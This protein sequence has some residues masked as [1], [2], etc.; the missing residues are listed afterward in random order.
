M[1]AMQN[2]PGSSNVGS[3]INQRSPYQTHSCSPAY[4]SSPHASAS[5]PNVNYSSPHLGGPA[6]NAQTS[7]MLEPPFEHASLSQMSPTSPSSGDSAKGS[8]LSALD[9]SVLSRGRP[10]HYLRR[11]YDDSDANESEAPAPYGLVV[12]NGITIKKTL[13][14]GLGGGGAEDSEDGEPFE[15]FNKQR[16]QDFVARRSALQERKERLRRSNIDKKA[17]EGGGSGRRSK[18]HGDDEL[19]RLKREKEELQTKIRELERS[20][21][22]G[23]ET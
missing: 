8:P 6:M 12:G 13:G 22:K 21:K 15:S 3:P 2:P 19:E 18:Q 7:S 11:A 16:K 14:G 4:A 23:D 10:H 1:M 5:G 20:G 17:A 9:E